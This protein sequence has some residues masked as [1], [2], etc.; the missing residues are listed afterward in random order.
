MQNVD[1]ILH[2]RWIIPCEEQA[3]V[4]DH[5]ALIIDKGF[6]KDILPS[7]NVP[8]LYL[9]KCIQHFSTH[10]ITP[11]FINTH[12]HIAMNFFR[13]LADD[14]ALM[15]WLNHHIWPAEKQ[16]V[17]HAF[18]YDAS[19]FAMAEMI[20]C[21]TTCFNDMYFFLQATAKAAQIAGIRAH[22]GITVMDFPTSWAKDKEEYFSKGLEF[23]A[24]Y[25][26]HPL[27]TPTMAPHAIYTVA[28]PSLEKVKAFAELHD[29]KINMHVH[30]TKDEIEQSIAQTK[31]RP[32]RR[33]YNV[34]L[35]SPRLIAIHMT[36]I[37][38]EDVEILQ[39]TL[40]QI[41]HCPE[42]NMK[43]ASGTCPVT[44]LQKSGINIALGTDG[45]ASNNDLDMVSEMRS[46][47]FLTKLTDKNPT[48]L[49]AELALQM[50]TLQ[51]A[52]ALGIDHYTGSLTKGKAAD[53]IAIDLNQIETQPVYHPIS[54]I[55]YAASRQQV[56][57]VWVAGKQLLK[58]RQLTT[59]DEGALL[60]KA[61]EWQQKIRTQ[62]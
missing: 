38:E 19:L 35:M 62:A 44:R 18:V 59:L 55:V 43:L 58:N 34:G 12:T 22:I 40:P 37:D 17:D 14:L 28:E 54:Q 39:A 50:A 11:G 57:D 46:A 13:G 30:E 24:E 53:C 33:L 45:A 41:V 26:N 52:K 32:I 23:L 61:Q 51:G 49:S 8:N 15:D 20:R 25:K 6:I 5:H 7:K 42:S 3:Q 36:Q 21:G 60:A 29:L 2:A 4:L 10:A 1:Q 9:S 48:A 47:A 16:W 27:I 31:Q 56:T